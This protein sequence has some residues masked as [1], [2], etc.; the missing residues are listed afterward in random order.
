M[1]TTFKGIHNYNRQTAD[2]WKYTQIAEIFTSIKASN[3]DS[4]NHTNIQKY[5]QNSRCSKILTKSTGF[6]K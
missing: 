5:T 1:Y 6:Q 2:I 3:T 4:K